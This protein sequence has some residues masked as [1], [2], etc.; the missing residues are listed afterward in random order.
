MIKISKF[1]VH[2]G[3]SCCEPR[4]PFSSNTTNVPSRDYYGLQPNEHAF[5]LKL[6][7]IKHCR[8]TKVPAKTWQIPRLCVRTP[9]H[10]SCV[11]PPLF[12]RHCPPLSPSKS[13]RLPSSSQP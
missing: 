5:F 13:H 12:S 11:K 9:S 3:G 8:V 10:Q 7:I 6:L 1:T 4:T 2:V